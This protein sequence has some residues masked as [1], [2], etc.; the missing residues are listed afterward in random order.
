MAP[1]DAQ[2]RIR[3]LEAQVRQLREAIEWALGERD[4]FPQEPAPLAGKYRRPYYW[5]TELRS[6]AFGAA[7]A[8]PQGEEKRT[9]HEHGCALFTDAVMPCDCGLEGSK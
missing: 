1:C 6:R 2:A 9:T 8:Q 5:R 3:E 7:L 4:E